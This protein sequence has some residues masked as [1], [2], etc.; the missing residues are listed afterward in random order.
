M[1]WGWGQPCKPLTKGPVNHLLHRYVVAPPC[2]VVPADEARLLRANMLL[3]RRDEVDVL[4]RRERHEHTNRT[5]QTGVEQHLPATS[6]H[7]DFVNARNKVAYMEVGQELRLV[8]RAHEHALFMQYACARWIIVHL[9]GHLDVQPIDEYV[10]KAIA[11]SNSCVIDHGRARDPA[12]LPVVRENEQTIFRSLINGE[13]NRL[14]HVA[15]ENAYAFTF[16]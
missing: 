4:L 8:R 12:W 1:L 10:A 13:V 7:R 2:E 5:M 16:P 3:E 6:H 15:N 14:L 11:S 9:V